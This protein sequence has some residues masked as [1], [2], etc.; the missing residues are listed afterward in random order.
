MV[1]M[2]MA[3]AIHFPI[4]PPAS[5]RTDKDPASSRCGYINT[6]GEFTIKPQFFEAQSFSCGLAA[7]RTTRTREAPSGRG[8]TWGFIDK[9]GKLQI[10]AQFNEAGFFTSGRAWVHTGGELQ[11]SSAGYHWRGGEWWLIDETGKRIVP[12]EP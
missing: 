6:R 10:S 4:S 1:V 9:T 12:V 7:V 8:D 3:R 5:Q 11:R 2:E